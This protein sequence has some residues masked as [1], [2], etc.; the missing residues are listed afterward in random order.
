MLLRN[1]ALC[2]GE[3]SR[4]GLRNVVFIECTSTNDIERRNFV[5]NESLSIFSESCVFSLWQGVYKMFCV[6]VTG[7]VFPVCQ[8][9]FISIYIIP[10]V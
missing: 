4:T 6:V 5:I 3:G 9:F 1:L 8:D 10:I 7:L 2:S